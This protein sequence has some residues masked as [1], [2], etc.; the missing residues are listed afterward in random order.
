MGE[1]EFRSH[2]EDICAVSMS[3]DPEMWDVDRLQGKLEDYLANSR[4]RLD[5]VA[6]R[7]DAL[8]YRAE[9]HDFT[10]YGR[11]ATNAVFRKR[12]SSAR[13]KGRTC[14][15]KELWIAA[16][17]DHCAGLG[18]EDD[19]SGLAVM[20]GLARQFSDSPAA[21]H[22]VFASFDLEERGMVGSSRYAS[23]LTDAELDSIDALVT[24]ECLGSGS[25]L[26]LCESLYHTEC[27][28]GL[29]S[30]ISSCAEKLGLTLLS[31]DYD[32]GSDAVPFSNR[33]V[34]ATNLCSLTSAYWRPYRQGRCDRDRVTVS[35]TEL[36]TPEHLDYA[37]M[38]DAESI[39][40]ELIRREYSS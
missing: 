19:A 7:F 10:F 1:R 22:L 33:G 18:A 34:R 32:F 5:V 28:P 6:K 23:S 14:A 8:G 26:T 25:D 11:T 3:I 4:A 29:N 16:H 15:G 13:R 17:H 40:A 2:L 20:L 36:D 35:H 30:T 21:E 37:R 12:G 9:F 39:I 27:D 24:L 38:A 31:D